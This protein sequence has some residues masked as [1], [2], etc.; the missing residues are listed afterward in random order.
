MNA[1]WKDIYREIKNTAGRFFSLL[2]I[3]I[4]GAAS[5][6][7]IQATSIDM[8]DAADRMYKERNLYD[9]HIKS[10]VGFDRDDINALTDV[11][12][13]KSVM[14][15]YSFDVYVDKGD[16][17]RTVRTYSTHDV[18]AHIQSVQTHETY[19]TTNHIS[20]P[21]THATYDA[22]NTLEVT[23]GRLPESSDECVVERRFLNS[24][25][26]EIGDSISFS[27]DDMDKYND[28]LNSE[29]FKIVGTV[30]SPLFISRFARGN[31][32]LGDGM[33]NYYVYLHPDAYK[34]EVYTDVYVLME[35]SISMD[36]LSQEYY[37]LTDKWK[38][39]LAQTG[40]SQA[41]SKNEEFAD[42]QKEIDDGWEKYNDGLAEYNDGKVEY[43]EGKAEFDEK[44]LEFDDGWV[45]YNDGL[46][47]YNDGVIK[48]E[49][50]LKKGKAKLADAKKELDLA[51]KKLDDGQKE[52]DTKITAGL[53]KIT[54][55]EKELNDG[56]KELNKQKAELTSGQAQ[57]NKNRNELNENLKQLQTIAPQGVSPEI[58]AQYAA[59]NAG[60]AE[61][62]KKQQEIN[63]G[64]AKITAA[65][66]QIN[67]GKKELD[68]GKKTL[69]NERGNAQKEIDS[70]KIEYNKG[71]A[72]Y[73]Q[74]V[75][76]LEREETTARAEL[77]N[78]K[79]ELDNAERELNDAKIKIQDGENEL[80]DAKIKLQDAKLELDDAKAEL[81]DAQDKLNDAPSPEWF[82]FTRKDGIAYDSYFQ[83]TLRLEKI[84]YVFPLVFFLVAIMVS[85]TTMSR[86]VEEQR[87]Q[88]GIYKALG[89][90][91]SAVMMK[92]LI[93]AA[94]ASLTGGIAGVYIGSN[95]FPR[96]I[97][98]AYNHMYIMPPIK[99]PI[100]VFIGIAAIMLASA[101]VILVTFATCISAMRGKPAVLM[102]PKPPSKG[103]R[104]FMERIPFIWNRLNFIGKVTARNVFRYKKRFLMTLIGVA[105]CSALLVT[106]FGLRDSLG[107]VAKLQYNDIVK[108]NALAYI[109]E[110]TTT[111]QYDKFNDE[112]I[113]T[114]AINNENMLYFSEKS[115]DVKNGQSA[116]ILVPQTADNLDEY[117]NLIS[118]ETG[119]Y[120]NF[121]KDEI[122]VTEKIA[123]VIGVSKGD[124]FEVTTNDGKTHSL[125]V[126]DIVEN[127]ILHYIYMS[128]ETYLQIFSEDVKYNGIFFNT[129]NEEQTAAVLLE[130]E[131]VRAFIKVSELLETMG[132]STDAMGI[133]T[134][135]LIILACSLA[136]V[137][138]FNLTNINI[139]E[140]IRELATLK[141]LGFYNSELSLY[142]YRENTA[143]TIMGILSGIFGGIMLH[144]FV[145]TSVE[146]DMLKFPLIINLQSFLYS[147]IL[148]AVF[149][150]FVNWVMNFKLAKIDMVESLKNVE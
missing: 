30:N 66:T 33:L 121:S 139:T 96:I 58:D 39:I 49:D 23:E 34:I 32:S 51:K 14:P 101:S 127:Y 86:M 129:A 113:S 22:L 36:N 56:Q 21:Q 26:H 126:S 19:D 42:A 89:Y 105:G 92:Y 38:D 104:V 110:L 13:V 146:I 99:T 95:L 48:L 130:N 28:M 90:R 37:D 116:S 120:L 91:P 45:Q 94:G 54:K 67:N 142:V 44:K 27:L 59:I 18:L 103:K 62:E 138:L 112:I 124:S 82:Y 125:F 85:L 118:M 70:G 102:R 149:A 119:E 72:E 131:D 6:V 117:I 84:G 15:S 64:Q 141:V 40:E 140:R 147:I 9:F 108:Y 16:E 150:I 100:P 79:I 43:E 2:I 144:R 20:S 69:E 60:L 123:R 128:P 17:A 122:F 93:Y 109:K 61:I 55:S 135:V 53:E 74:G 83:D 65:Q 115:V 76:E 68:N 78:A 46:S 35:E 136:L 31:T 80:N 63:A 107:G 132:D 106:A 1:F 50:E 24:S 52:L 10:T 97:A 3:T 29:T 8:R 47:E 7:G 75:L 12:G 114:N 133:V 143:V 137:V 145:L 73:K 4:L 111:E 71:L 148:S 57:I 134:I 5:F 98:D 77:N 88:M 81:Q 87:T 11:D 25:E 41:L